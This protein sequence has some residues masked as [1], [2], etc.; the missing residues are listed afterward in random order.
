MPQ[1][2]LIGEVARKHGVRVVNWIAIFY[3]KRR[4]H[5]YPSQRHTIHAH[6][7]ADGGWENITWSTR[8]RGR[9][10]LP[11]SKAAGKGT[12]DWIWFHEN[13]V[14]EFDKI[15]AELGLDGQATAHRHV[16]R[17]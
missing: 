16:V 1:G 2:L 12:R 10:R 7:R 3:R 17:M 15:A 14:K 11:I 5:L 4:F 8:H 6:D 9:R 13:R